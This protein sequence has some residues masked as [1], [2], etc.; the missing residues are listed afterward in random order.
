MRLCYRTDTEPQSRFALPPTAGKTEEQ[1]RS[2]NDV[3]KS[4]KLLGIGSSRIS[5]NRSFAKG[6]K[7][8]SVGFGN[9]AKDEK[10]AENVGKKFLAELQKNRRGHNCFKP[11]HENNL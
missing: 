6:R 1:I 8:K 10:R 2:K 4:R 11:A 5:E 7:T 9:G 3:R